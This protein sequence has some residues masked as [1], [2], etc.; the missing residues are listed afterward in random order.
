MHTSGCQPEEH[1]VQSDPEQ[2]AKVDQLKWHN[3]ESCE[4]KGA[5]ML[6][7]F[8]GSDFIDLPESIT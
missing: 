7:S 1:S 5:S 3:T 8:S 2:L 4:A 6:A